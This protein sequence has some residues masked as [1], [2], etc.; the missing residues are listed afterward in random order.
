MEVVAYWFWACRII[1][2]VAYGI[3]RLVSLSHY[4]VCCNIGFV[5]VW[6]WSPIMDSVPYEVCCSALML[7]RFQFG[8][9]PLFIN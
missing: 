9:S 3:C 6:A 5:A 4:W 2:F 1:G 8:R 7:M